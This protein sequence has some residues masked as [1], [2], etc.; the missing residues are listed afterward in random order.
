MFEN[1]KWTVIWLSI[2]LQSVNLHSSLTVPA[3]LWGPCPTEIS[4][5]A[6]KKWVWFISNLSAISIAGKGF[7]DLVVKFQNV[8][9]QIVALMQFCT[10]YGIQ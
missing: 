10:Y 6:V 3:H 7:S 5:I 1:K 8:H 2:W 9:E 4:C